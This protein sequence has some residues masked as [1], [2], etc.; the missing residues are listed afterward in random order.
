M[1]YSPTG[2][3]IQIGRYWYRRDGFRLPVIQGGGK[4]NTIQNDRY[5]FGDD[6]NNEATH[7]L[8]AENTNRA[9]QS[10]DVTFMLRFQ[11]E[12]TAGGTE[13]QGFALFSEKNG[14][15]TGTFNE[16]TT[17]STDGLQIA[18]D[19]QSRADDEATTERLTGGSGTFTAGKYDDGQVQQGT[20][21]VTLDTNYTDLEF[22]IRI[23]SGA[24]VDGDYWKFQVKFADGTDL[25][26]YPVAGN[27]PQVTA[28]L[29][30][31]QTVN[32]NTLQLQSNTNNINV[33]AGE[34]TI[35]TNTLELVAN[36]PSITIDTVSP[37][38]VAVNTLLLQSTANDIEVSPPKTVSLNT[39][40]LRANQT[41]KSALS[42]FERDNL[43]GYWA[44]DEISGTIAEDNS[45]EGNTGTYSGP[46]LANT[47]GADGGNVPLFDGTN[48]HV[49][50]YSSDFDS[51]FNGSEGTMI[52]WAKV[53]SS[54][55]WT[56]SN[57][58]SIF[59]VGIDNATDFVQL[60]KSNVN[61][62][63][64][65]EYR[66]GGSP[67][68]V[69][70][71]SFSPDDWFRIAIT[72]SKSL[73][74]VRGYVN[75]SQVG[76]T[77]TSLGTWSA[78]TL[79]TDYTRIG[80]LETT[81]QVWDGWIGN[82]TILDRALT[83]S[84]IAESFYTWN[85]RSQINP[86]ILANTLSLDA[87]A[88]SITID[89]VTDL[90]VS[91]VSL[92]LQ[93]TIDD[94]VVSPGAASTLLNTLL[95]QSAV[96]NL[97]VSAGAVSTLLDTLL[98]NATAN[99]ATV[100]PQAV[101]TALNTLLLQSIVNDINV[102]AGAASLALD[103]LLLNASANNITLSPAAVSILVDTLL[104]QS[105]VND[106]A[107][108]LGAST[109]SLNTLL[110]QSVVNNSAVIA[111]EATISANTLSLDATA[112]SIAISPGAVTTGLDTLLLQ[113]AIQ[114][115]T[116]AIGASTI[117][118]NSL[119]LQSSTPNIT[120]TPQAVS[121]QL[122]SLELNASAINLDVITT[123]ELT[124]ALNTLLAQASPQAITVSPSAT[125]IA[126]D[127]LLLEANANN[128]DILLGAV[129]IIL[130]TLSLNADAISLNVSPGAAST[131]LN[132]LELNAL[133]NDL[134][135]SPEAVSMLMDTLLL[136]GIA[137]ELSIAL[138]AATVSVDTLSLLANALNATVSPGA[139][140][141]TMDT[142]LLQ[143]TANDIVVST[144]FPSISLNTLELQSNAVST[145]IVPAGAT[146]PLDT[147]LLDADILDIIVAIVTE[148]VAGGVTISDS[149]I[150][151]ILISDSL[152]S[153]VT[154][155]DSDNA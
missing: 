113:S 17:G 80:G 124:V 29:A 114:D 8:D 49:K 111:G 145:V 33:Q 70:K 93:S 54:S 59:M 69:S 155:T 92:L 144:V 31:P 129:S 91:V 102:Q 107:V 27:L 90:T 39:L 65:M 121:I 115:I 116:I 30:A 119:L 125:S 14:D 38:T 135:I 48:D 131:Q 19:T 76:A 86:S 68:T 43:I 13:A 139:V 87:S 74:E 52:V 22:A 148:T 141:T 60:R 140:T 61:N 11:V 18:N 138:G 143:G 16:V 44:L 58:R 12:E 127:T 1:K 77:L 9:S 4:A 109:V 142:L 71:V 82:A 41:Y 15:G 110:L 75:G 151:D 42:N 73:D 112:N 108:I 47:R 26:G 104:L 50:I 88:P 79:D 94:V 67:K 5:A 130:D 21:A 46:N 120:V 45:P 84:E 62:S 98:L 101:S 122:G 51:D 2:K 132:T 150:S 117:P 89:T 36:T 78:G 32:L 28:S 63:I 126:L 83:P 20:T 153:N 123:T 118:L 72:W 152:I 134:G 23:D 106:I 100:S 37:I 96:N 128:I 55:V 6:D 56:D 103:T 146:L 133:A 53:S 24:A 66:A 64:N 81:F 3:W 149:L 85:I 137:N 34:A 105:V 136:Q 147:L 35:L 40:S 99:N 154:V 97:T 57:R 7:S 95:L 25:D 10:G